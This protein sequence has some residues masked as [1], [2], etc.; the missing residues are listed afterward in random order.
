MLA[1]HYATAWCL[2]VGH[3][4]KSAVNVTPDLET[5]KL[6]YKLE[7]RNTRDENRKKYL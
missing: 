7:K 1:R 3:C 2:S 5:L 4:V 6:I